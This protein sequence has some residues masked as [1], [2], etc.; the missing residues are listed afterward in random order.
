MPHGALVFACLEGGKRLT[1][2]GAHETGAFRAGS[3]SADRVVRLM[4]FERT[5]PIRGDWRG[6]SEVVRVTID[7]PMPVRLTIPDGASHAT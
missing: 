7:T 1:K 3:A 2:Y 4:A 6:P 5:H